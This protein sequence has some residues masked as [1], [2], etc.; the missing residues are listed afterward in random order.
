MFDLSEVRYVKR[1]SI[2]TSNPSQVI[3]E[4]DIEKAIDLLNKCLSGVPPGKIIGI[5]KSFKVL[6]I[7]EHQAVL[8]WIVY[9]IGFARKP[10]W[11]ED[12]PNPG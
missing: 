12:Q 2:G 8:Q 1:I 3:A 7:G 4:A 9:H 11:L 6:N 10:H 5:E